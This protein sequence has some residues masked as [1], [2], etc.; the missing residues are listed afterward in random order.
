M[1]A[2][3]LSI[4]SIFDKDCQIYLYLK[5]TIYFYMIIITY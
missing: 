3:L 4:V 1:L 2:K 5:K